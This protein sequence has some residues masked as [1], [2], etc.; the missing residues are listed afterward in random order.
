MKDYCCLGL[1]ES[2]KHPMQT[3]CRGLYANFSYKD[4]PRIA[5]FYTF[6]TPVRDQLSTGPF[7]THMPHICGA[8]VLNAGT[9]QGSTA[10]ADVS[11]VSGM[12][13]VVA[14]GYERHADHL[15][16]NRFA[17]NQCIDHRAGFA[18]LDGQITHRQRAAQ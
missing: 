18:V 8:S 2:P 11:Q 13:A 17:P 5:T 4:K 7:S 3:Q 15:H 12:A 10:P 1:Q 14:R 9:R 16:R 6:F